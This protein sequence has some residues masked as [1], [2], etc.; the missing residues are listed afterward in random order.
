VKAALLAN[1]AQVV[2][3][4]CLASQGI[5]VQRNLQHLRRL[6]NKLL[7]VVSALFRNIAP[8][9]HLNR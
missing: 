2:S 8:K 3:L 1:T 4:L 5:F 9:E 6:L 7:W